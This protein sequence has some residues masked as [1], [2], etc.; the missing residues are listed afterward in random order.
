[1]ELKLSL[2]LNKLYLHEITPDEYVWMYIIGS[3]S[4]IP[5][6]YYLSLDLSKLISKKLISDEKTL[7]RKGLRFVGLDDGAAKQLAEL[8][9]DLWPDGVKSGGVSVKS[10]VEDLTARFKRFLISYPQYD[11]SELIIK[12][13]KS[14]LEERALNNYNYIT[15]AN[16]FVWK[17]GQSG[18]ADMCEM[19][20]NKKDITNDFTDNIK[21]V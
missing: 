15:R 21:L 10:N 17:E 6:N 12:A 19:V 3:N 13:T 11:D 5:E 1:M 2:F 7:T 9:R 14:Y 8:Y 16:Y 4:Y 20:L 18:L